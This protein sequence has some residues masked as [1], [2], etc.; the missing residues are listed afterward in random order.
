MTSLLVLFVLLIAGG[1]GIGYHVVRSQYYVG[2]DAGKVV[3][4]RGINDSLFG[5][6]LSSVYQRSG[7]PLSG[8]PRSD[9]Q[10]IDRADSVSL[11]GAQ[12]S[13]AAFRKDYGT[14]QAAYTALRSWVAHKPKGPTKTIK[15]NGR[16]HRVP[17]HYPP[18]PTIPA[19]CPA[20]S[21]P[22]A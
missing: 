11:A 1:L 3:I 22:G 20:Q 14:C 8:L 4:F 13:V 7:I 9:V 16:T 12:Q 19:D 2:A 17:T 21:V 5:I 15:V 6:S 10:A 18:K